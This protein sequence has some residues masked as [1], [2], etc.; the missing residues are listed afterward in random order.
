V[1]T[2]APQVHLV[3]A[4]ATGG[5]PAPAR[6]AAADDGGSDTLSVIALIVGTLGLLAGLAGL[7]PARRARAANQGVDGRGAAAERRGLVT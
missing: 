4:S 2:P 3:P 1:I 5:A 7:A 6:A